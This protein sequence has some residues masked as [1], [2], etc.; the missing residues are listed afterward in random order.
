[1]GTAYQAAR[2]RS[3]WIDRS[4]RGRIVVSGKDR[5]AYLQGLLTN[6]IVAL[7]PGSGCYAAWLTPQGRMITDAHVFEPG[8]MLLLH[9]PVELVDGILE[10]L[11]Q[12]LFS[13]DVQLASLAGALRA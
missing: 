4:S 12:F 3:G 7:T 8:H 2:Q 5:A 10:R 13:E 1:M 11:D 9:V 6:D